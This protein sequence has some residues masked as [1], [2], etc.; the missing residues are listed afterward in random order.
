MKPIRATALVALIIV[1]LVAFRFGGWAVI[2]VDMLP[3]HLVAGTPTSLGFTV[4]QHGVTP[5]SMLHPTVVMKSG[6]ADLTVPATP[7]R[8]P[9]Q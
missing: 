3:T 9:G 1:P 7:G 2:T 8:L 5:L 6:R 4:R